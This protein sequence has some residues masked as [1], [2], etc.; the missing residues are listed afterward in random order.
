MGPWWEDDP[1]RYDDELASLDRAGIRWEIDEEAF[2][3][4]VLR[5]RVFPV[6][7]GEELPLVAVFPDEYPWFKF[8]VEAPTLDLP[9]HQHAFGKN[10]CLLPRATAYWR[11]ASDRLAAFLTDRLPVVLATGVA[12]D[13]PTDAVEEPQAEPFSDYYVYEPN[14]LVVVDGAW[15]IPPEAVSGA[16]VVGLPALP[17]GTRWSGLLRGAVLEVRDDRSGSVVAM[18]APEVAAR[19]P[20]RV[21]GRWVRLDEPIRPAVPGDVRRTAAAAF[22]VMEEADP[23]AGRLRAHE[24]GP[25]RGGSI[26]VRAALFP[27]EHRWRGTPGGGAGE[28]WLVAVCLEQP[29][30]PG[31]GGGAG[32]SRYPMRSKSRTGGAKPNVTCYLA[33]A[34][35]FGRADLLARV[36]EL[37]PMIGAQ[38][39]VVGLGCLGAP[40]AIEFARALTGGLRLVEHD[41]VDAATTV[42]WPFGLEVA[43][44]AK[45]DVIANLIRAHYPWTRLYASS[46]HALRVGSPRS[47]GD[48]AATEMLTAALDG[49]SLVYD[50]TAEPGVQHY[51]SRLA[52]RRRMPYVAVWGTHGAWGGV[53]LRIRPDQTEGCWACLRHAFNDGTIP[54]PPTDRVTGDVQPA[55]CADPTYTGANFDLA[56]VALMGVRLAV[57]TVCASGATGTTGTTGIRIGLRIGA[58]DPTRRTAY[59]GF[60]WDVAV[61]ALRDAAGRPIAPTWTTHALPRHPAC[62][63]TVHGTPAPTDQ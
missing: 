23:H 41:H 13:A 37:A 42:R 45:L 12:P 55:G 1:E 52:F 3:A 28:G 34:G 47:P 53:V 60:D 46:C 26:R 39:A 22:R 44:Q 30:G 10:L 21:D 58:H 33:R 14:T 59:G 7:D 16:L 4:G 63:A 8:E 57:A 24:A 5:L 29:A 19:F 56:P 48:R 36:P 31:A 27:E 62:R 17:P 40:S 20:T 35:R 25:G 32:H 38:V 18:M 6:I 11:P 61:L 54:E 9:H 15:R 43:G 50:A 2:A 49:A 51:L